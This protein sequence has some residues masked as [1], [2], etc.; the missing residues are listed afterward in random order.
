MTTKHIPIIRWVG[1]SV[2]C[3]GLMYGLGGLL[4]YGL[5]ECLCMV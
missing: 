2:I 4:M 1:I 3:A 5:V